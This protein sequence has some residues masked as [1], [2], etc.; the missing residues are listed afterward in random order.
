VSKSESN[1]FSCH[2][3]IWS[4]YTLLLGHVSSGAS[5]RSAPISESES[6]VENVKAGPHLQ[7][8]VAKPL[9]V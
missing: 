2:R 3:I 1:G 9:L 7:A 5:R 4:R 6:I 8:N